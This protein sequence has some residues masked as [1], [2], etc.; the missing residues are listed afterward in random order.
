[1]IIEK[2][3]I[4]EKNKFNYRLYEQVGIGRC[5]GISVWSN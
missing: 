3:S 1:M 4:F 5:Y 2:D